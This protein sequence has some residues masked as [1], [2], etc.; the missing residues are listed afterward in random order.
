M[1]EIQ[2]LLQKEINV[3]EELQIFLEKR[4]DLMQKSLQDLSATDPAYFTLDY[5]I[6]ADRV[7]LDELQTRRE[8]LVLRLEGKSSPLL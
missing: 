5:Q 6:K 3:S 1:D 2:D 8:A 7:A 4:I